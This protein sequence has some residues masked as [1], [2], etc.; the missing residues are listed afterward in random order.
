MLEKLDED[1]EFLRKMMFSDETSFHD[2]GKLNRTYA[3]G[4]HDTFMLQWN[5]L[6]TVSKV[7]VSRGLL[8]DRLIGPFLFAEVTVTSSSYLGTPENFSYS[9]L[10]ELHPAVLF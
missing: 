4:D 1:M 2:S 8:H 6:Q 7:I 5:T 3:S 10:Q 9:L